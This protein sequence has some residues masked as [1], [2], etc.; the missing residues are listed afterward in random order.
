MIVRDVFI[1]LAC[2]LVI[3]FSIFAL[4]VYVFCVAIVWKAGYPF[5]AGCLAFFLFLAAMDRLRELGE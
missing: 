3:A 1:I 2:L 4:F 5:M